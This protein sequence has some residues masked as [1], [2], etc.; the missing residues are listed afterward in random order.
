MNSDMV[1]I[2]ARRLFMDGTSIEPEGMKMVQA[3][4]AI[5]AE[6][7]I[8]SWQR[9]KSLKTTPLAIVGYGPSLK[10]TWPRLKDFPVIWSTSR[11]LSFLTEKGITPQRHLDLDPRSHKTEFLGEP[12]AGV[13]YVASTHVHPSY[14]DKL[15]EA[16][17][18]ARLFHVDIDKTE[19]LDPRYASLPVCFDVGVQAAE[20]AYQDGY[21]DQHWFGIEYG[22]VGPQTHAGEHW[23]LKSEHCLVDVDGRIFESTQ[24]FV[25]GLLMAEQFLCRRALVKCTIYGDGLLGNFIQCRGRVP[26]LRISY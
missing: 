2:P 25:H 9:D 11:A 18:D 4:R 19:R 20:M 23:G 12:P 1:C 10:Y 14:T 17:V 22:R 13:Q 6:K 15:L 21:R 24:M 8:A 26:R 3:N 7:G 16:K 5:N